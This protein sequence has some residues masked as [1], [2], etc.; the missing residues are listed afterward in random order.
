MR[1]E[2]FLFEWSSLEFSPLYHVPKRERWNEDAGGVDDTVC[3]E[4]KDLLYGKFKRKF[5][6]N[7]E[8]LRQYFSPHLEL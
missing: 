8:K 7:A 1:R 2:M 3:V 4:I 6:R 5:L